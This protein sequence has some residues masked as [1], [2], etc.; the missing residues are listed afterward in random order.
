MDGTLCH[1]GELQPI[2]ATLE[3]LAAIEL[4]SGRK[5]ILL[6]QGRLL[7]LA[8]AT[9]H[10][11]FVASASFCNQVLA[12]MALLGERL[13]V[14]VHRIPKRLDEKV[15]RLHLGKLGVNLT[16]LTKEQAAYFGRS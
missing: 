10:Q 1:S 6:A 12:Q 4:P 2:D 15:A 9:G 11:S 5:L 7:N 14:D 13:P 16:R 3:F 8:C